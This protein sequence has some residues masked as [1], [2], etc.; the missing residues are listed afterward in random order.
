VGSPAF[1]GAAPLRRAVLAVL[2][3][4]ALCGIVAGTALAHKKLI[5]STVALSYQGTDYG[6]TMSGTV[7]SGNRGCVA[8]RAM[9]LLRSTGGDSTAYAEATSSASGGFKFDPKGQ[10]FQ[11]GTYY[12]RAARK[13]LKKNKRHRHI[14]KAAASATVVVSSAP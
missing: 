10:V 1:L 9:T 2:V 14:C 7:A 11:Q 13:V 3:G 8:G 4:A 6:D 5:P 12:A